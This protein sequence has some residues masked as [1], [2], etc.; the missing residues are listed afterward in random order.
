[1]FGETPSQKDIPFLYFRFCDYLPGCIPYPT[2]GRKMSVNL[3][4]QNEWTNPNQTWHMCTLISEEEHRLQ[5]TS[6]QTKRAN[7]E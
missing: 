7:Q 6:E 4:Q 3:S 5:K 2:A 1:M